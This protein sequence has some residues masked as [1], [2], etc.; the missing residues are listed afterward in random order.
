M[1]CVYI[2]V[3]DE[4]VVECSKSNFS[5]FRFCSVYYEAIKPLVSRV[6]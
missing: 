2:D 6:S 4:F 3:Q 1:L 5:L